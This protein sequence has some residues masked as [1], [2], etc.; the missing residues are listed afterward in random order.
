[1]DDFDQLFQH[2]LLTL[3]QPTSLV[4]LHLSLAAF[5]QIVVSVPEDALATFLEVVFVAI[6]R[7]FS[8]LSKKAK[9]CQKAPSIDVN[10]QVAAM[11]DFM[12]R[13]A[14]FVSKAYKLRRPSCPLL[15]FACWNLVQIIDYSC[16][17]NLY[18]TCLR[19]DEIL[20]GATLDLLRLFFNAL[21]PHTD[22]PKDP[23]S[24]PRALLGL[25]VQAMLRVMSWCVSPAQDYNNACLPAKLETKQ[26]S[27]L[28]Q[29][30]SEEDGGNAKI[31]KRD[32]CCA[33]VFSLRDLCGKCIEPENCRKYFASFFPG[34]ATHITALLVKGHHGLGIEV[35]R[36]AI[37]CLY[38]WTCNVVPG[39]SIEVEELNL[40]LSMEAWSVMIEEEKGKEGKTS[41]SKKQSDVIDP[42]GK[43]GKTSP[44]K[45]QPKIAEP[46]MDIKWELTTI[47]YVAEFLS[48][49][50]RSPRF[51]WQ[52]PSV[53][54]ATIPLLHLVLRHYPHSS[55]KNGP[56]ECMKMLVRCM[57]SSS[58][59][60]KEMAYSIFSSEQPSCPRPKFCSAG[61]LAGIWTPLAEQFQTLVREFS[62]SKQLKNKSPQ[63]AIQYFE[64]LTG[65]FSI[66]KAQRHSKITEYTFDDFWILTSWTEDIAELFEFS[67]HQTTDLAV[68]GD[69]WKPPKVLTSDNYYEYTFEADKLTTD[70]LQIVSNS[71]SI[72]YTHPTLKEQLASI[73]SLPA[74]SIRNPIKF[75]RAVLQNPCFQLEGRQEG[76]S[77]HLSIWLTPVDV[78]RKRCSMLYLLTKNLDP[79]YYSVGK[80][81][82]LATLLPEIVE[83]TVRGPFWHAVP[84]YL[85]DEPP[86][87]RLSNGEMTRLQ[88]LYNALCVITLHQV[89][90]SLNA[91][92]LSRLMPVIVE[93]I[94]EAMGSEHPMVASGGALCAEVC[95]KQYLYSKRNE[96]EE[97]PKVSIDGTHINEGIKWLLT[98]YG[99]FLIDHIHSCVV[100]IR[101]KKLDICAGASETIQ[102]I[103]H[104]V[105]AYQDGDSPVLFMSILELLRNKYLGFTN[106]CHT[107]TWILQGLALAASTCSSKIRQFRKL[108]N[109]MKTIESKEQEAGLTGPRYLFQNLETF[110]QEFLSPISF[111]G[112]NNETGNE[113]WKDDE[114]IQ[115]GQENGLDDP[116][117]H[118]FDA[119][120]KQANCIISLAKDS[121]LEDNPK[122]RFLAETAV[123][124]SL[125]V[126]S[127]RKKELL[128]RIHDVWEVLGRSDL[129]H[130]GSL[131]I[132]STATKYAPEFTAN[133]LHR[134]I[135]EKLYLKA[136]SIE[137][138]VPP[139]NNSS[140][141]YSP[142]WHVLCPL[143]ELLSFF[144][145]YRCL[146]KP[147][148]SELAFV[149][150]KFSQSY[151]P[152]EIRK[153]AKIL[154]SSLSDTNKLTMTAVYETFILTDRAA[155]CPF[156]RRLCSLSKQSR[157]SS[158]SV[159]PDVVELFQK[160]CDKPKLLLPLGMD[161][162]HNAENLKKCQK[163][164]LRAK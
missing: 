69:S 143:L 124:H 25:A 38:V 54:I 111:R 46:A 47:G 134:K 15:K 35:F 42:K 152:E 149:G 19:K 65:Y 31:F 60:V 155:A 161:A 128:P 83:T 101:H 3:K 136:Q 112:S 103:Y 156:F 79:R 127:T 91:A 49:I 109:K 135:F 130:P 18:P 150:L 160:N 53:Q 5:E 76:P 1:M 20:A 139:R 67:L 145:G 159:S 99:D 4:E 142:A 114:E 37:E 80:A 24:D 27:N 40:K 21:F 126:L 14:K 132:I 102:R 36:S 39:L 56:V 89:L 78:I 92:S 118:R 8:L 151:Y 144:A 84:A 23:D 107:E 108:D 81:V 117:F 96:G 141:R 105:A 45:Q 64:E 68:L 153:V 133:K 85:E 17:P 115:D 100:V 30:A 74:A 147:I 13:A 121:L 57:S 73:G 32:L 163:F 119:H 70:P 51:Y 129:D 34:V 164:F 116:I 62:T 12:T 146:A 140:F 52:D 120:R 7:R 94:V 61:R 87:E 95:Y 104:S 154:L 10:D 48:W 123:Y 22:I 50:F 41:P 137:I 16:C 86:D 158:I 2:Y 63:Q 125:V 98:E 55:F 162:Q 148:S 157:K 75:L 9:P 88:I 11:V 122:K 110:Q 97:V 6:L 29:Y 43:K 28:N 44:C 113:D 138:D 71:L 33:A 77:E 131:R 59:I 26:Q 72:E 93:K 106:P 66:S 58:S 82:S 90:R